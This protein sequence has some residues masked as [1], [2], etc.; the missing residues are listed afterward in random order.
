MAI[1]KRKGKKA[2][3][4]DRLK[5]GV[6]TVAVGAGMHVVDALVG[7]EDIVSYGG[8][9]VGIALP[10]LLPGTERVGDAVA[11]VGAYKVA[12]NLKLGETL[13]LNNPATTGVFEGKDAIGNA[14]NF[15][16]SK[17]KS[18]RGGNPVNKGTT[19]DTIIIK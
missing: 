2:N 1:L 11:A 8:L 4:G 17:K 10:I 15:F 12:T 9:A 19:P 7:N 3:V 13:G 18:E 6:T 5:S 16:A 14:Q